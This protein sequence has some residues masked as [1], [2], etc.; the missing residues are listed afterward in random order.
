[1]IRLDVTSDATDDLAFVDLVAQIITGAVITH[2]PQS[3][4]TFKIDHWFDHKWLAFS[5]K[6]LGAVG[7]WRSPL[8]VP[9][10]VAN[11]VI[12]QIQYALDAATSTYIPQSVG[13]EI[14]HRG[15]AEE[16]LHRFVRQVA[17][18]SALF[19]YSGDTTNTGRGSLMGYIPVEADY[20]P[21]YLAF[22]RNGQWR[23]A[24]R[25]GI[26]EY[27]ARMFD[28]TGRQFRETFV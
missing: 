19:W 7:S 24:R 11:R 13:P 8:T 27:V 20:W 14:H 5:G 2:K 17:P 21:W 9:P 3:V 12:D 18:G 25:K 16:N 15:R 22:I 28:K 1:M 6:F 10:F 23:I 26:H 4:F